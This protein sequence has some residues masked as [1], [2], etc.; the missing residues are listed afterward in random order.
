MLKNRLSGSVE[1]YWNTTRDLLIKNKIPLH[2]GYNEQQVN[3]GQTSNRGLEISLTGVIVDKRDFQLSAS[4]NIAF[5]RNKVDKLYGAEQKF[6]DSGWNNNNLRDY[7]LKEGEPVGLMYGYV[8]DGYYTVDDYEDGPGW[9]LK[10]GVANSQ[11][12]TGSNGNPGDYPRVGSLK[13]KKTTPYD[14]NDPESCIVTEADRTVIGNANPKHTGGFSLTAAFKGF[15]LS[16]MFNWVYGNSIYNAQKLFN[17]STGKYQWH[18][19]RSEMDSRHRFRVFDDAGNDL[20]N[21]K[22]ALRALNVNASIWSP[23]YQYPIL[24]SWAIEDGSFLRLSNLTLGYTLPQRITKKVWL[25][26]CRIYVTATNLFCW[27]AYTGFDPEVD[28][29]RSSPLT[30]GVDYSAYPRTRSFA[31]GVNLIF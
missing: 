16:A 12:I 13:L 15:D 26:K 20:R 10:P 21:D 8:T 9:V 6:Y 11:N 31:F 5:N 24:H 14:P 22:E 25:S 2:T 29:R 27:T 19:L 30:P 28:T 7:L 1:L 4:F 23:V 18:N 3:V 17:T